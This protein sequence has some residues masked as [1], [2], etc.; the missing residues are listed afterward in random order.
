MLKEFILD[1]DLHVFSL[2]MAE[3]SPKRLDLSTFIFSY[4][5]F[6]EA[7]ETEDES[8]LDIVSLVDLKGEE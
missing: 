1:A 5:G 4:A 8:R 6:V 3:I 7:I 2:G